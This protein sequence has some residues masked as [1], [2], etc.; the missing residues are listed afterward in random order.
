M[1]DALQSVRRSTTTFGTLELL[2]ASAINQLILL[3][4]RVS[5]QLA[6]KMGSSAE[7]GG[8]VAMNY[9]HQMQTT[10]KPPLI[11]NDNA[12]LGD[13]ATSEKADAQAPISCGFYRLEKGWFAPL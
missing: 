4:L 9:F 10:F 13:V 11:A 6:G 12:F 5:R 1:K 2:V 3:L 8:A 7:D